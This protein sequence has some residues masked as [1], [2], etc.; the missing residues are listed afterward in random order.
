MG[1]S[2]LP[3]KARL[4]GLAVIL[5]ASSYAAGVPA[6]YHCIS[7]SVPAHETP[8]STCQ[9]R[10][11]LKGTPDWRQGQPLTLDSGRN[12]YRGSIVNLA[13]ATAYEIQVGQ[14]LEK[15]TD[16]LFQTETSTRADLAGTATGKTFYVAING[17]NKNSGTKARPFRTIQHA[18]NQVS[19]GDLV[20]IENGRYHEQVKISHSGTADKCIAFRSVAAGNAIIDADNT[21]S[22]G[23]ELRNVNHVVIEGFAV[24]GTKKSGFLVSDGSGNVVLKNNRIMNAGTGYFDSGI[25]VGPGCSNTVISNNQILYDKGTYTGG[26]MGIALRKTAGGHIINGNQIRGN[27]L[28][29]DGIGG[30]PNFEVSG[31]AHRD[32]DIYNN[33]ITGCEDDGIESEGGNINVRIWGNTIS[34]CLVGIGVAPVVEGPCYVW[35]N[36]IINCGPAFKLGEGDRK[37]H[38]PLFIYHNTAYSTLPEDGGYAGS[39]GGGLFTN[40]YARNNLISVNG[41]LF[42]DK[43]K[44]L[45]NSF[46]YDLLHTK[47][48]KRFMGWGSA[49]SKLTLGQAQDMGFWKHAVV[50]DPQF[51]GAPR[52]LMLKPA[53]PAIDAGTVLPNFNDDYLG[54][55]PDIGATEHDLP[56]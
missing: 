4:A 31:G 39:G 12:E 19:P 15:Q 43:H 14:E 13:Q 50:E 48:P 16:V 8:T 24:E 26:R 28:I 52:N 29:K 3:F 9:V 37:G 38:G 41:M 11:R 6:T 10:F 44:Q 53:S 21:R 18:A 49:K 42:Y 27:S 25:E 22:H 45:S 2:C 33:T 30:E 51:V 32:S 54:K 55:A 34:D 56:R 35:R 46:D 5:L 23:F 20:I 36:T 17:D 40:V 7:L 47:N 1:P